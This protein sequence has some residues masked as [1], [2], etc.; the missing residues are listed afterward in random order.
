MQSSSI[1]WHTLTSFT[2]NFSA[3]FSFQLLGHCMIVA[4]KVAAQKGID[5][6]GY[7]VV[8]NTGPH[9][10]Q[11]VYHIHLHVMG[12]RQLKWPPGWLGIAC[13]QD[14]GARFHNVCTKNAYK[15]EECSPWSPYLVVLICVLPTNSANLAEIAPVKVSSEAEGQ[16]VWAEWTE[17]GK[18][19]H[20]KSLRSF[21]HP[22]PTYTAPG[23]LRMCS[24]TACLFWVAIAFEE[25][26]L[27]P[28]HS[29]PTLYVYFVIN[30]YGANILSST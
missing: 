28:F 13:M 19:W 24:G 1:S 20:D 10:C 15:E 26:S 6:S 25:T 5:Q 29:F 21:L 16:L 8:I 4:R 18:N 22:A 9:G 23:F 27:I 3:G 2:W 7:R 14:M 11:S 30:C 17:L 12:G